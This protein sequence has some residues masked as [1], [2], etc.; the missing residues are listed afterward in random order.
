MSNRISVTDDAA[1]RGPQGN[2]ADG[3]AATAPG[4]SVTHGVTA[5]TAPVLRRTEAL[6]YTGG[7]FHT[8]DCPRLARAQNARATFAARAATNRVPCP[9][10]LP[11]GARISA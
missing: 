10:C 3:P 7:T 6:A 5:P 4:R 1:D 2:P 11:G 9:T 8:L